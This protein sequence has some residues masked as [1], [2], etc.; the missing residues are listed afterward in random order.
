MK[1]M[2]AIASTVCAL[3]LGAIP[4]LYGQQDHA[5]TPRSLT[6]SS[7]AAVS[8]LQLPKTKITSAT[9]VPAGNFAPPQGSAA[10]FGDLPAFCRIVLTLK[11]SSDSDIKSEVWLPLIGWN[12]KFQEAGNGAWGG[13]VQ[14]GP[15]ADALRRGYAAASTDTGHTGTDASFA[16]GHPEKLLDFG[17][18]AIHETALKSKAIINWAYHVSPDLSYF[19]GCSGGGRQGFME[20]QRFPEDFDAILAGAPGYDRTNQSF[21]LVAVAQATHADKA[22]YIPKEKL[23]A[24]HKAALYACDAL[25]GVAD[26]LISDPLRCQF[27]PAIIQCTGAD[28]PTCLTTAQVAAARKLYSDIK[29]PKTGQLLFP[30]YEPGSELQWVNTATTPRPLGMSDD[31]FKSVVFKDQNWDFNSLDLSKHL[32]VAREADGGNITAASADISKF[33]NRG[34]KLLMYHGWADPNISPRSS[35]IYY[36]RLVSTLG[37][38]IVENSVRLYMVPGMGHCGGGDGPNQFD[39]LTQLENWREKAQAPTQVI[40]S[41]IENGKVVR[42]RPLCPYPQINRYTGA[43]SIDDAKNFACQ[44]P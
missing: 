26:G 44:A 25:D 21:Q 33:I 14:Y 27:D 36:E 20:A 24:L 19:D 1:M 6:A 31:L 37:P 39:M 13:S 5:V 43:G 23:P 22:S 2:S 40:A 42:T 3:L 9:A 15:L 18:R 8:S 7:C 4:I 34:G 11:P 35:T 38:Q 32:E 16:V 17:Y 10:A 12:G 30:G 41:K 28:T 29:D